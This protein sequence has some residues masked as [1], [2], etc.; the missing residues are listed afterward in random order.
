MLWHCRFV[1]FIGLCCAALGWGAI[2]ETWFTDKTILLATHEGEALPTREEL[3]DR[4]P[5]QSITI[6]TLPAHVSLTMA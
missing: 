4:Y 5:R 1:L 6:A 3:F 2:P